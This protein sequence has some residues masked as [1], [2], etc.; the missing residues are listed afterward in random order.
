VAAQVDAARAGGAPAPIR[1]EKAHP[2]DRDL[3][4]LTRRLLRAVSTRIQH[5]AALAAARRADP[6]DVSATGGEP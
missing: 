3:G 6:P 5:K 1:W 4:D 2:G